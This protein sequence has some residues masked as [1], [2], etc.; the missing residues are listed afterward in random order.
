M[1]A[2]VALLGLW[3]VDVG[4]GQEEDPA[5]LLAAMRTALGGEATLSAVRAWSV[6]GSLTRT[7]GGRS[8]SVSTEIFVLLPDHYMTVDRDSQ[9]GGPIAIDITYY[10]GFRG[11]RLIRR[12][13]STIPF[14]PDPGPQTPQAIADRESRSLMRARQ[15]FARVALVL[16]GEAS[17]S[18]PLTFTAAGTTTIDG[19]AADVI[20]AEGVDGFPMTLFIDAVNHLPIA[21]EWQAPPVVVTSMSSTVAVRTTVP[22]ARGGG[23]PPGPASVVGLSPGSPA[24]VVD[25]TSLPLVTQRQVFSD[26]KLEDGVN[27][28]RRWR[29][30]VNGEV[31]EDARL[32]RYRINPKIEAKKFDVGR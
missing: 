1:W 23:P 22:G 8:K 20:R 13:D 16:F 28:P 32:G 27:W 15:A 31:T 7:F 9:S 26:F 30:L 17:A 5:A 11:D 10:N 19:R 3:S 2:A 29:T 18:Y 6:S 14:P 4:R 21:L 24:P 12:T 25:P